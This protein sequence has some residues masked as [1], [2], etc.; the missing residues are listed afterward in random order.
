MK[1][2][3]LVS[4]NR[5]RGNTA[6]IVQMIEAQ[7]Q[8]LAA[9]H[10][11]PLE[12]ETLYLGDIEMRP[13]RGCRACFD[14]GEARCPLQDDMPLIRAKID[15][16]DGLIIASPVYVNDVNGVAKTWIDRL[17]YI[18]HRPALA[19]KCA[20]LIATVADSPTG[21]ALQTMNIALRTWGYHIVGQAGYKMGPLLPQDELE[22]RYEEET[23]R[24]AATLFQAIHRQQASHPA[25]LSLMMFKIQQLAWQR[26]TPGS[27]DYAYWQDQGWLDPARTFYIAHHTNTVKV[28][29]ARLVGAALYRFIA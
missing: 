13:C 10:N 25:F 14:R 3:A 29:L 4:S 23:A 22:S 19:G 7:S 12:F 18:C 16:A 11:A 26:G 9:R 1:I 2:L 21:H 28:A 5:K 8:A 15:A 20:Y 6:R 24:V 17:A 27:L